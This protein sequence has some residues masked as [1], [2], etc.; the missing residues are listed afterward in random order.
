MLRNTSVPADAGNQIRHVRLVLVRHQGHDV[1]A[2]RKI[3]RGIEALFEIGQIQRIAC[4]QQAGPGRVRRNRVAPMLLR[5]GQAR[6]VPTA[7]PVR[8][9]RTAINRH[10]PFLERRRAVGGRVYGAGENSGHARG[11]RSHVALQA[12]ITAVEHGLARIGDVQR[13]EVGAQVRV[14]RNQFEDLAILH[15]A[16]RYRVVEKK[17]PGNAGTDTRSLKAGL[18]KHQHLR[19]RVDVESLQQTRQPGLAVGTEL[20]FDLARFDFFTQAIDRIV[21]RGFVVLNGG[22]VNRNVGIKPAARGRDRRPEAQH[23]GC[24]YKNPSAHTS[25]LPVYQHISGQ[26][27]FPK[28]AGVQGCSV[29]FYSASCAIT[30]RS[31]LT[32]ARS[33]GVAFWAQLTVA[34]WAQLTRSFLGAAH[35]ATVRAFC[36]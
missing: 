11:G 1:A 26:G 3:V 31:R 28:K 6:Y 35:A 20:K 4:V 16:Y 34:F 18:G 12:H 30:R 19:I 33:L 14:L 24:L 23:Q 8:D 32:F 10:L 5:A 15:A 9:R 2:R 7:P 21:H 22:M 13:V 29:S 17:S 27:V 25:S 36:V